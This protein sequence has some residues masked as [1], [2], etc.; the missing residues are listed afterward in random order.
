MGRRYTDGVPLHRDRVTW[1]AYGMLGF[2]A[3]LQAAPGLVVPHLRDELHFSYTAGGLHVALFAVGTVLASALAGP[4]ERR[5]GRRRL[6]W[7]SA[8]GM[9]AGAVLL[10]SARFTAGTLAAMVVMGGCGALLLVTIQAVLADRHGEQR[11]VAL[12]EANVV[13]SAAYV[14]L[15]GSL[16]VS[17]ALALGWRPPLVAVLA[18]IPVAW[19]AAG[20]TRFDAP[21]PVA[22]PTSGGTLPA[23]FWIAAGMMFFT[24]SAEWCVTAWG[25]S[26]VH[27]A[28]GAS[29]D[30]AVTVM[31]GYFGGVL[32][33][34]VSGSRLARRL[35]PPK[36]LAGAQ[37]CTALGFFVLWPA[38]SPVVATVGL[39][40]VGLGM[41]NLFPV[42][43]GLAVGTAPAAATLASA[44]AV[45]V[46]GCAV[47]AAPLVVGGLA[48]ATSIEAALA[49]VPVSL[50]LAAVGLTVLVRLQPRK[51]ASSS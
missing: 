49:V 18:V 15:I 8:V 10:V 38:T 1:L 46:T 21:V 4:G 28:T 36:L 9:G 50:A 12:S 48:D 34:R 27:T 25:A 6:F 51:V 47:L 30:E 43:L 33:G 40:L 3:F 20:R 23:A 22:D 13:A 2:F 11:T 44:R 5:L 42:G 24:T 45:A 16:T 17:A 39:A 35:S 14:V 19:L 41:G 32:V 7:L 26:F 29:V 31:A 37:A